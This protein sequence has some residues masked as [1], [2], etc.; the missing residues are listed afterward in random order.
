MSTTAPVFVC[1]PPRSGTTLLNEILQRCF[2]VRMPA[3]THYFDQLRPDLASPT[4]ALE[5]RDRARVDAYFRALH[6]HG[7]FAR[8]HAVDDPVRSAALIEAVE[9]TDAVVSAD[10]WFEIHCR[11]RLGEELA[12]RWGEK[13]PR[14]VF[15]I[16]DIR[17]AFPGARILISMRDPR[18]VVASY[19]AWASSKRASDPSDQAEIQRL[20]LTADPLVVSLL[21]R[22]SAKAAHGAAMR[23]GDDELRISRFEDLVSDPRGVISSIG[24]WL[25]MEPAL[26][27]IGSL[28]LVNSSY[29]ESTAGAGMRTEV[30][31]RWRHLLSRSHRRIVETVCGGY[32]RRFDYPSEGGRVDRLRGVGATLGRLPAVARAGWANRERMTGFVDFMRRRI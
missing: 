8:K 32:A 29:Q 19:L 17:S 27:R 25:G 23:F 13:S 22:A 14:H 28:D 1:G 21:W 18:A 16:D 24:D 12:S 10:R 3:E 5:A 26:D 6:P 9:A 20:R 4:A 30:I 2:G 11:F 31:D 7:F 15:R